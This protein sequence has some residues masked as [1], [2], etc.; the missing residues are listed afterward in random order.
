MRPHRETSS[1]QSGL[2]MIRL[3]FSA[4]RDLHRDRRGVVDYL[5]VNVLVASTPDHKKR[6]GRA[7]AKNFSVD[8]AILAILSSAVDLHGEPGA[9][10]LRRGIIDRSEGIRAYSSRVTLSCRMSSASL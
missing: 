9:R 10:H 2:R 5:A 7:F 1:Q 8:G 6:R 4:H 3:G